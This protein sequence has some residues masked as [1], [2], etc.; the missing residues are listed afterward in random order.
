MDVVVYLC[1]GGL[2]PP[3]TDGLEYGLKTGLP[4]LAKHVKGSTYEVEFALP[5]EWRT[6]LALRVHGT[7]EPR[8][9]AYGT[10]LLP[11]PAPKKP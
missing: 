9:V 4:L 11:Q 7:V 2:Q 8:W 3:S 10:I 5:V 1:S 6:D